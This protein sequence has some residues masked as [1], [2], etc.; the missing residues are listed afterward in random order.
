MV[1]TRIVY[2]C[3]VGSWDKFTRW[4]ARPERQIIALSGQASIS[5][6]YNH[7]LDAA[8][9]LGDVDMVVLLH[10]DLEITDPEGESKLYQAVTRP[11]VML[12][13]VAGGGSAQGLAWWNVSPVGHQRIN[14]GVLDFGPRAGHVDVLE[15]SLLAFSRSGIEKLRFDEFPGFHSYDEIALQAKAFGPDTVYVADVETFHHTD[16]G[17]KSAE[18]QREW[19]E[20]NARVC[21]K[22]DL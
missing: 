1:D 17:F 3:C 22:W 7:V 4:V 12:A 20:G 5:V 9:Y 10:D 8:R 21:K 11:G 16:L 13:G 6:A 18:S 2:G 14:S 19:L 15:G